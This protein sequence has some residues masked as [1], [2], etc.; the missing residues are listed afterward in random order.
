MSITR[1]SVF[2]FT[3]TGID[4]GDYG[5]PMDRSSVRS[6][7]G[8]NWVAPESAD[9]GLA[10]NSPCQAGTIDGLKNN[11]VNLVGA[12]IF[13]EGHDSDYIVIICDY[14]EF[15]EKTCLQIQVV[16][17]RLDP[18]MV[19]ILLSQSQLG[20]S[21]HAACGRCWEDYYCRKI[22][23]KENEGKWR[24]TVM[25]PTTYECTQLQCTWQ[26]LL[27]SGRCRKFSTSNLPSAVLRV[28]TD[29][30]WKCLEMFGIPRVA[31]FQSQFYHVT[32][33][34]WI[35]VKCEEVVQ[36]LSR[37][38]GASFRSL[39]CGQHADQV[40]SPRPLQGSKDHRQRLRHQILVRNGKSCWSLTR[41]Q[42]RKSVV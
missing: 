9:R 1:K 32:F 23:K 12:G 21:C 6:W 19:I 17:L 16:Y 11:W 37:L 41:L 10:T 20:A 24:K 40:Q 42:D 28:S 27:E 29:R 15:E 33:F 7:C 18:L 26:N 34:P 14:N 25:R 5:G 2:K 4:Y 22:W 30:V 39:G 8:S 38:A 3:K 31:K 13:G 36:C 35:W